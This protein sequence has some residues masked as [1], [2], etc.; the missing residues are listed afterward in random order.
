MLVDKYVRMLHCVMYPDGY[1][2]LVK[3][4]DVVSMMMS[5]WY[6]KKEK[7]SWQS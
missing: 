1:G 7:Y 3:R 5:G 4:K 2:R 6:L